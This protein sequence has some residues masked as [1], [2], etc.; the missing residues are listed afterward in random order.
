MTDRQELLR[1]NLA[2][3][4]DR[5]RAATESAGRDAGSVRLIAVTKY[6]DADVIRD[7]C[8]AGSVSYTHLT[9]PTIC[10]V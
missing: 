8:A 4:Q 9:L 3:V 2:K 5:I 1:Q 7:L 10:S 6:V